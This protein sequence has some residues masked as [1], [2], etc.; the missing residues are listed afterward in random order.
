MKSQRRKIGVPPIATISERGKIRT[1]NNKQKISRKKV[2]IS[3]EKN[4]LKSRRENEL[5]ELD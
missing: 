1:K 3:R 2:K 4:K 5:E